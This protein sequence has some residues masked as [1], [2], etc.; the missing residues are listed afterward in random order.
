MPLLLAHIHV[1][2]RDV[3]EKYIIY[4]LEVSLG[5]TLNSMMH[6]QFKIAIVLMVTSLILTQPKCMS[7]SVLLYGNVDNG[8]C[9]KVISTHSKRAEIR[10]RL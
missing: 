7:P 5:E 9:R 2:D 6:F 8:K 1:F 3:F 10:K 4:F